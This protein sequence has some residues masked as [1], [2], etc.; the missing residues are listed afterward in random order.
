MAKRSFKTQKANQKSILVQIVEG[1]SRSPDECS[2]IGRCVVRDLPDGLPAGTPIDV[3]FKYEENGRLT[4]T[5]TVGENG[6]MLKHEITRD[7]SLTR[8]QLDAWRQYICGLAP[9]EGPEPA[10]AAADMASGRAG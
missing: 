5:V 9:G 3:C 7:N 10:D 4:V 6:L 8:E 2:Q 1:E